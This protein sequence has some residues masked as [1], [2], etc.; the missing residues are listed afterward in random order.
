MELPILEHSHALSHFLGVLPLDRVE[1]GL[2]LRVDG[3]LVVLAARFPHFAENVLA[4]VVGAH[5][6]V[7]MLGVFLHGRCP[8]CP[9]L[10][11]GSELVLPKLAPCFWD[12]CATARHYT[13]SNV[14][15]AKSGLVGHGLGGTYTMMLW[16]PGNPVVS[17][18]GAHNSL[19]D[20]EGQAKA[21]HCKQFCPHQSTT[22]VSGTATSRRCQCTVTE[23]AG[24]SS[25][26]P[27]PGWSTSSRTLAALVDSWGENGG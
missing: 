23:K 13:S 3:M 17:P 18:P 4:L 20:A 10:T 11:D 21:V 19:A 12:P 25:W 7:D 26:G 8:T 27:L 22:V 24:G 1:R 14:N 9:R 16:G 2:A 6:G 5:E 15:S